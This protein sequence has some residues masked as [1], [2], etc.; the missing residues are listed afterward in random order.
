MAAQRRCRW[1]G[2]RE[3]TGDGLVV[4]RFTKQALATSRCAIGA[5]LA[6]IALMMRA[7]SLALAVFLLIGCSATDP[8]VDGLTRADRSQ[9]PVDAGVSVPGDAAVKTGDAAVKADAAVSV[10]GFTGAGA[11]VS[12]VPATSAAQHHKSKGV[13]VVPSKSAA[14]LNCHGINGNAPYFLFGGTVYSDVAGTQPAADAE[15]RVRGGDGSGFLAHSDVDGNFWYAPQMGDKLIFAALT[16]VRGVSSKVTPMDGAISGA[17]C[18][19]C[20]S[21]GGTGAV[22]YP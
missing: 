7:G 6:T 17:D 3:Y 5:L 13:G 16:A 8:G 21:G 2:T 15:V 11:F 22:H 14:C 18:N 20:H 4:K 19:G 12:N 9:N 1:N 10:T